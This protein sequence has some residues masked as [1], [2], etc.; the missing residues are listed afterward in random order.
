[1]NKIIVSS[2]IFRRKVE[3]ALN[4][5]NPSHFEIN[6]KQQFRFYREGVED[7]PEKT[8]FE[9]TTKWGGYK[10]VFRVEQWKRVLEYMKFLTEQPITIDFIMY[11]HHDLEEH[12]EF[13]IY[14]YGVSF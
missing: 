3:Y 6:D 4:H 8:T 12:P 13:T 9:V 2:E 14:C 5:L 1:M 11:M 7:D 10:G